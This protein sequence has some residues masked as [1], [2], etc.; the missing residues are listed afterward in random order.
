MAKPDVGING[1]TGCRVTYLATLQSATTLS[2]WS[3]VRIWGR[4]I[5]V[6]DRPGKA[7]W[8]SGY[9]PT[10]DGRRP[11]RYR[12]RFPGRETALT[13]RGKHGPLEVPGVARGAWRV[14][15]EDSFFTRHA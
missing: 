14:A 10:L 8:V 15:R 1:K 3:G 12:A 4:L 9:R 7:K 13:D 5:P 11:G 2:A 6:R